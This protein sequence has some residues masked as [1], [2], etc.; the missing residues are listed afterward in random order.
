[1]TLQTQTTLPN[2]S[3]IK[4]TVNYIAQLTLIIASTH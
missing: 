1:M 3:E 4:N 2:K